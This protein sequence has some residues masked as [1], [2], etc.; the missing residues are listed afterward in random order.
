MFR[1]IP[2]RLKILCILTLINT[3]IATFGGIVSLISGPPEE[4]EI[5]LENNEMKKFIAQMKNLGSSDET[6]DLIE[7]FQLITNAIYDN[8]YFYTSISAI[9]ALL[10]LLSAFFMLRR[11]IYGFHL[12][13]VYSLLSSASLYLIVSPEELPTA[14]IIVNLFI[15]GLF[16]YLYSRSLTWLKNEFN[17]EIKNNEY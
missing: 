6:I 9:L 17:D 5:R 4:K 1:N 16:I 7:K 10:G 2:R 12:Y 13:I 11:N 14:V 15:S 3:G 8:F